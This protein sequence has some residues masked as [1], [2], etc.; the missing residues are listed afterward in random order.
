M[1]YLP[2][3]HPNKT[4]LEFNLPQMLIVQSQKP[5]IYLEGSRGMGKSTVLAWQIKQLAVLMPRASMVIVG[6]T[7]Q[8]I[9]TRTLPSTIESLARLGYHKDLHY[10]VGKRPPRSWK[11]REPYQPPLNYEHYMIWYTG[12]GFHFVSQDRPG[13]GRGLNTDAVIG[14]EMQLLDFE[15]LFHDVLATNRSNLDKPYAQ[16]RYHHSTMFVGTVPWTVKGKWV[17][18]MEKL[19]AQKPD[20]Y[21]YLRA[22]SEFNRKNLGDKWFEDNKRQLTPLLYNAEIRGIRPEKVEGGFYAL[23]SELVHCYKSFN[24]SYLDK[25]GFDFAKIAKVDCRQDGDIDIHR[26]FDI[27][28]DWGANI[29]TLVVRQEHGR[30]SRAV[31]AMYVKTPDRLQELATKFCDYY[32]TKPNKDVHFW[33]DHTAVFTDA[34]RSTSFADEFMAV[35]RARKWTVYPHYIG[36]AASHHNRYL[37]WSIAHAEDN[38]RLPRFRYNELHAKYLI[39]SKQNAEV[40][41]GRN[42]FEK[43]KVAERD[44]NAK[45]EETTHFSDAD[46]TLCYGKYAMLTANAQ[47]S[48]IDTMYK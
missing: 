48:F 1:D 5:N 13:S 3:V 46:D 9:L 20:E 30:E 4:R 21:F 17:Y 38:Q 15:T 29:N 28:C 32:E 8:Q 45:Q 35:L 22:S 11:W 18:E 47:H 16:S 23:L 14:D 39:I 40:L 36:Q 27:A 34:S 7:Y 19:A 2:Q 10:F 12:A 42:G 37:F 41:Q 44:P 43:S 25:L 26:P 33:Y 24:Y 31:H 6:E